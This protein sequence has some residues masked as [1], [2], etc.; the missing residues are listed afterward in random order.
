MLYFGEQTAFCFV[1]FCSADLS[2]VGGYVIG[3]DVVIES[4][5]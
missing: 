3:I 2:Y 1:L 4:D 5:R